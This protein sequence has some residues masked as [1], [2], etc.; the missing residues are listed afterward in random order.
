MCKICD[1]VDFA[2]DTLENL[3]P[4]ADLIEA[5]ADSFG[6]EGEERESFRKEILSCHGNFISIL[7]VRYAIKKELPPIPFMDIFR[8][9]FENEYGRETAARLFEQMF[10]KRPDKNHHKVIKKKLE[11][12]ES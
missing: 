7:A 11:D 4:E 9:V 3:F 8:L 2:I 5:F 1:K 12:Y 6:V 10:G